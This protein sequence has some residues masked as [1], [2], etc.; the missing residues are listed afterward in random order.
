MI[1]Q[2]EPYHECDISSGVE[3]EGV[4]YGWHKASSK[5]V[6]WAHILRTGS[7][8]SHDIALKFQTCFKK[9]KKLEFMVRVGVCLAED[10]AEQKQGGCLNS[11]G[12]INDKARSCW[13]AVCWLILAVALTAPESS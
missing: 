11:Q 9:M 4:T 7:E 1:G 8:K 3:I 13:A 2:N 10:Q 12:D 6:K 5:G